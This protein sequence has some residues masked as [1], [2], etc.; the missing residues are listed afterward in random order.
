MM[1]EGAS[2]CLVACMP[3]PKHEG[4]RGDYKP[5]LFRSGTPASAPESAAIQATPS[6]TGTCVNVHGFCIFYG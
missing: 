2:M 1:R 3:I 4:A 6:P 5:D